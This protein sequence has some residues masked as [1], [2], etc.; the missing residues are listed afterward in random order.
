MDPGMQRTAVFEELRGYLF[1][2]AYRMLGSGSDAEDVHWRH[3][4][5]QLQAARPER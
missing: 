3:L 2:L 1:S 5:D 4:A